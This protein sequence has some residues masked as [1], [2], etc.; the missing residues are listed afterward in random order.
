MHTLPS[1]WTSLCAVVF[2]LGMRHGLDA[3]HL[4]AIDG[5]TRLNQRGQGAFTRWCGGL[6][7]LGHGVV[8]AAVAVA[9]G[10]LS[11]EW[12]PPA[13]L[14]AFGSAT[15][16]AFL[17]LLGVVNLRAVLVAPAGEVLAPVGLRGRWLGRLLQARSP[18]GVA[19]VGALFALSF[20]TVS[21]S[22]LFAAA[23]T[24]FGG[25]E[26]SLTLAAAF[27]AGMLALDGLNGWW[28]ARL[29]AR[30]DRRAVRASRVMGAVVGGVS[31]LVAGMAIAR[32]NSPAFEAWSDGRE[33]AFGLT[34]VAV[35]GGGY[36]LALA[37]ARGLR[38]PRVL[39]D[40]EVG[41]PLSSPR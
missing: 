23:A 15:S 4:A 9:V 32:W 20:D 1:D 33:L 24:Q 36:L 19:G 37:S 11:R 41:V 10:L 25:V 27:V 29:I 7:S 16:I 14:E 39:A 2:L 28:I 40:D 21:Q 6:F 12:V 38:R 34:V 30:A 18:A 5:L 3:D 8:V 22:A 35:V 13:W 31:L 26:R 17:L